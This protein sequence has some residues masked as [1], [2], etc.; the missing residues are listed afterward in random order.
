MSQAN[1]N[2]SN[3]PFSTL[4]KDLW[5]YTVGYNHRLIFWYTVRSVS[6]LQ[7]L[8][9]PLILAT[10]ANGLSNSTLTFPK[11][12]LLIFLF[13]LNGL[14]QAFF[15]LTCKF[16]VG[17]LANRIKLDIRQNA[18][19]QFINFDLDWH[20][21]ENSGKKITVISKGADSARSLI[22]FL[23]DSGGG[24][25]IFISIIG[26]LG[27]MLFLQPKYFLVA[28]LNTIVYIGLN[29]KQNSVLQDKWHN[30]NKENE[31]VIGKNYDYFS[32]IGLIKRL[33]I[34]HQ[35][36]KA[37]F[38]K[39]LEFTNK[40]IATSRLN[41]DKWISI[42]SV[43]QIF[44]TLAIALV[45]FDIYSGRVPVGLFFV[46]SGYFSKL[47]G[48]LSDIA[49]S[50]DDVIDNKLGFLRLVQLT[51]SGRT[52]TDIGKLD[53]PQ[54]PD[55][56]CDK[57]FFK[58]PRHNSY[59]LKNLNL[60]IPSGQ[61]VGLVGESGSGKSTFTKILLRL[62]LLDQGKIFFDKTNIN[63]IRTNDLRKEF[64]VVP[65]ESEV[66]NLTFKENIIIASDKDKFDKNLYQKA[67]EI[68]ECQTILTKIKNNHQTVLGE[69]GV[70]L[71]GGERQRLGIARA[72]YKNS[73]IMI[74]DEST[75]SLDSKTEEKILNNIENN[76]QNKTI[77]WIAHR[78]STLRFTDRIVVFENGTIVEDGSFDKL[79]DKKGLFYQLWQIQRRSQLKS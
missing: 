77:I 9:P 40:T 74:F 47:Q 18:L 34:G 23:N 22:R 76:L 43:S 54:N 64:A 52:L 45:V 42:Q 66:F 29:Q 17:A 71:S 68:A 20:E 49:T 7:A 60:S 75:S 37:L 21:Q 48:S 73:P 13:A 51:S 31:K 4:A 58:Y 10:L 6:S 39:E 30:L 57:V 67:I 56:N 38:E 46:I 69:K 12:G 27:Y 41:I 50:F 63:N 16:N 61:K 65:Q 53:S 15:R 5:S 19:S 79:V 70:K 35:V 32:N 59:I 28:L 24:L 11:I 36:N 3:Y 26:V 14:T 44:Q 62:Y 72:I 2:D 55:I 25:D 8:V 33:G 78:L 1:E